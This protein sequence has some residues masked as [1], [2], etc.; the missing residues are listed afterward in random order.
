MMLPRRSSAELCL[1]EDCRIVSTMDQKFNEN[2]IKAL[3]VFSNTAIRILLD[4]VPMRRRIASRLT[5][6][7]RRTWHPS[8]K[9]PLL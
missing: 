5:T 7:G 3:S 1:D 9:A 8:E 6:I 2:N 4:A